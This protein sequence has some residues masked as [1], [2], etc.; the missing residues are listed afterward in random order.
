MPFLVILITIINNERWDSDMYYKL[1]RDVLFRKYDEYGLITDNSE[2]GYR[3]LNDKRRT[4]GEKYVSKSG[5]FMLATLNRTPKYIDDIVDELIK[6]FIGVDFNTLKKDTIDFFQY[7]VEEGFLCFGE[8]MERCK[9]KN[10]SL[11]S[12]TERI[13]DSAIVVGLDDCVNSTFKS[14]EFLR[15]IHIEI[16]N[17][18]NERCVHCYI[19]HKYKTDTMN[20][21]MFYQI[22]EEGRDMNIIHVTLSGGEPL[23]HNDIIGFL[24]RC[25]ELD[26]SVN[27]LSNL[28]LLTDE[29]TDEMKRNPFLSVQTSLYSMNSDIHDKITMMSGSFDKTVNGIKRL[30]KAGIPVQIS[31]P[32]MKQNKDDFV[33]VIRWGRSHNISVAV[34]PVIFASYDHTGE[35]LSNRL[36]IEEIGEAIDYQFG[37]GYASVI[38]SL[39]KEKEGFKADDPICSICIYSFCISVSGEVYPCVGWQT[40]VI[41]NIDKQKLCEIWE[42][43]EEIKKLRKVKR[44]NFPKCV[45]CEDR[46]YCTVCMMSNSNE[47]PDGDAFRINEFHCEVAALKHKKMMEYSN[48]QIS[49]TK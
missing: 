27:V 23:L 1:S 49:C 47:N 12:T 19:P 26:L 8:T 34:E 10:N 7:F 33:N 24:K 48:K 22:V 18:C 17:A 11:T 29:I 40:N 38:R 42:E 30:I 2:Y 21:D 39:A 25:R 44:K 14:H 41:G 37:E 9:E 43:S 4:L 46:G 28:T 16:A 36:S 45:N 20:S 31:C 13:S 3:M 5:A 35:N 32:V 6:I 15:S